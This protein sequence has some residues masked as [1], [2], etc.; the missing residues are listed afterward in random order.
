MERYFSRPQYIALFMGASR[1]EELFFEF[2]RFPSVSAE[3][4]N[5]DCETRSIATGKNRF[6]DKNNRFPSG[7]SGDLAQKNPRGSVGLHAG[8]SG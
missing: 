8:I 6:Q 7:I 3:H 2:L 4:E 1:I 5:R